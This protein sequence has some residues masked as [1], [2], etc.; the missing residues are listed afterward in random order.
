MQKG[1]R[2]LETLTTTA[3][4]ENTLPQNCAGSG[5]L[6]NIIKRMTIVLHRII[7]WSSC[8]KRQ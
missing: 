2:Y 7:L 3:R 6:V 5:M 1:R 8:S 4:E